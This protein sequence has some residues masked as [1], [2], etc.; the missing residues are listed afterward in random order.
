MKQKYAN[1]SHLL[2]PADGATGPCHAELATSGTGLGAYKPQCTATGQY[3]S[4][5]CHGST[6]YC[7]CVTSDG[8]EI[9]GTRKGP[10]QTVTCDQGN[11]PGPCRVDLATSGT[12]LGAYKPQCTATGQYKSVQCHG[13]TGY[14][15]CVTSDGKEINGTRKGPGQTVTCDQG[16]DVTLCLHLSK[17]IDLAGLGAYKPQCTATG[18]YKSKQCHAGQCWCVTSDGKEI[19]GTRKGPGQT[20]T[21][22]QDIDV[23]FLHIGITNVTYTSMV[24]DWSVPE[25]SGSNMTRCDVHYVRHKDIKIVAPTVVSLSPNVTAYNV[26]SIKPGTHYV[27][28]VTVFYSSGLNSSSPHTSATT[29]GFGGPDN[30]CEC[31]QIGSNLSHPCDYISGQCMCF[32]YYKGRN[33]DKCTK[34]AHRTQTM[35]CIPCRCPLGKSDG[36]C[37][38]T[39]K[40]LIQC[41]CIRHTRG[42]RCD[43][44]EQGYY[45]SNNG[46]C[47]SCD[48]NGNSNM[49]DDHTGMCQACKFN[50]TGAQCHLCLPGCVGDAVSRNC[51]CVHP[52][53]ASA[54]SHHHTVVVVAVSV[55][56]AA[57]LLVIIVVL[58]YKNYRRPSKPFNF[59]T[60]ELRDDHENV[61]FSSLMEQ[62]E[63]QNVDGTLLIDDARFS[64]SEDKRNIVRNSTYR[65][66][67]T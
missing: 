49:C 43:G 27:V 11:V 56:V 16:N 52:A 55:T 13:S 24:V 50:T 3:K 25:Y 62:P 15:W 1:V 63:G 7:W 26:T 39:Q 53:P 20:V 61:N 45:H 17:H 42:V 48:C 47:V 65:P 34:A 46:T 51:T 54:S 8:K 57:L 22:D 67:R 37:S 6:G 12:G 64:D 5:Q 21:C 19:N 40:G 4:V 29:P 36:T 30:Q 23:K 35:G 38:V 10:G 60:V 32:R 33:C 18:Q 9:N 59:W 2:L 14:C 41:H 66:V 28:Y 31:D 58:V 44:C